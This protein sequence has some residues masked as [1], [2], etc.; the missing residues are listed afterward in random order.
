VTQRELSDA[1]IGEAAIGDVTQRK[2]AI[3][4]GAHERA[5]TDSDS[6]DRPTPPDP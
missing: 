3:G 1:A 6:A 2:A 4:K 5:K